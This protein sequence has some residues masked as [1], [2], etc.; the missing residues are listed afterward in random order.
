MAEQVTSEKLAPAGADREITELREE[1]ARA[2]QEVLRLRDLL[3]GKD[4]EV[5]TMSGRVAELE[6]G[7]ARL[8]VAAARLRGRLAL[9][10]SPSAVLHRL[11]RTRD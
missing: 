7:S 4:A 1:L 5:G 8:V 6:E 2:Q 3:I 11:R 10:R 9:L